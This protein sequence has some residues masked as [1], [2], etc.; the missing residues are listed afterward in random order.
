MKQNAFS[1]LEVLNLNLELDLDLDLELEEP[2]VFFL[3]PDLVPKL[4]LFKPDV[5]LS[6]MLKFW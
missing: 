5:F 2:V 6:I 3:K 1:T 4:Q